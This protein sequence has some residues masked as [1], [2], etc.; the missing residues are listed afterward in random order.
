MS[1][2]LHNRFSG[3]KEI[4]TVTWRDGIGGTLAFKRDQI[5]FLG[6]G[7]ERHGDIFRFRPLGIPM[8][9]VN[10]PDYI[11]HILVDKG[12][13]YDKDAV[14]FKVVRPVLRQGLIA[15]ADMELW[16]RQ[17]RMMAP[18]FTPRTVSAFARN[19]TDETVQMLDRWERRTDTDSPLDITDE[20]G[21]LA[22]RIVNRSLFSADVGASA[23]AFE[24]AF[25]VANGILGAFF[26]FPFPPLSVPTPSHRRLRRAIEDM[27]AFVSG[28]IEKR[29]RDD[30]AVGEETDLLTLLLHTVDEEDGKG[31]DLEQLHHEVLNICVGAYETTTNTL[32]WTFY[33]LARHPEVE[34]RLHAEVDRVLGDRVP[35]FEDLPKLKYTR[36]IVEETLRIYSPAYQFMRRAR[37]EDEID[38][39]RMP[40]G[41]NVLINSYFLHRHPEFWDDPERFD[42]GRFTPE[43]VAKRPKHVY[44]PFGSGHRVCIGKHFALTELTLVLATVARRH[45]LLQPAGAPEVYPEALIT[46]HPKGGVHLRLAHRG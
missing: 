28:F 13:Q 31:M 30:V 32:S 16:R 43:E 18:H 38:G 44:V 10:H 22:L 46:L 15:N 11:R 6:K 20:I 14:L 9:L 26:R 3:P 12:E 40:A 5:T 45:R 7:L 19:M 1:L 23:Q 29:L 8:V 17:R 4:P 33:L 35:T 25:Q 27:D 41:T 24:R 39:Y 42:P 37:D 2:T 34:Q 21:Q 36:M